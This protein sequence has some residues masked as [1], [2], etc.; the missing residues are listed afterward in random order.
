MIEQLVDL[1]VA[2]ES[3]LLVIVG[4]VITL[5][6]N[7]MN[8]RRKRRYAIQDA[9]VEHER[10]LRERKRETLERLLNERSNYIIKHNSL[11]PRSADKHPPKMLDLAASLGDPEVV[12]S[13]D[14][15][16]DD[17]FDDDGELLAL[18]SGKIADLERPVRV[19]RWWQWRYRRELGM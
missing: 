14:Q 19:P 12:R 8:E 16:F 9:T 2:T 3:V 13:V 7:G 17:R 1:W 4:A 15:F 18:A 6:G 5:I 11:D 10:R